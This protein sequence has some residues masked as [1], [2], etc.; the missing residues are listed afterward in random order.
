[1]ADW[2]Y[3]FAESMPEEIRDAIRKARG[4]GP[5]VDSPTT[6]TAGASRTNSAAGGARSSGAEAAMRMTEDRRRTTNEQRVDRPRDANAIRIGP[7]RNRQASS[8]RHPL[9]RE[10]GRQRARASS[11]RSRSTCRGSVTR[12]RTSSSSPWHLASWLPDDPEG[13]TVLINRGLPILIEAIKYHQ[14]QYPD[15]YAEDVRG[16]CA[17][18]WRDRRL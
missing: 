12:A 16:S 2:G 3:E 17:D 10:R 6:S 9:P 18:L 14:D 5:T 11:V 8:P 15:V 1:M 13:P 7:K 4:E